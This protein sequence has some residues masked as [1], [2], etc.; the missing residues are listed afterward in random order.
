MPLTRKVINI[1]ELRIIFKKFYPISSLIYYEIFVSFPISA[2]RKIF[3]SLETFVINIS[4]KLFSSLSF[5][6]LIKLVKFLNINI[7]C[8]EF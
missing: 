3:I 5:L 2:L 4:K 8:S 1:E 6:Y 7:E